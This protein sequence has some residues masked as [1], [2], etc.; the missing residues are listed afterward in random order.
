MASVGRRCRRRRHPLDDDPRHHD[1]F[2]FY[3]GGD[4]FGGKHPPCAG[5]PSFFVIVFIR[6]PTRVPTLVGP[7][8]SPFPAPPPCFCSFCSSSLPAPAATV[9][10]CV[11]L[12]RARRPPAPRGRPVPSFAAV[13][14]TPTPQWAAAVLSTARAQV[15]HPRAAP[16]PPHRGGAPHG[17]VGVCA[18]QGR[19]DGQPLADKQ[20]EGHAPWLCQAVAVQNGCHSP[21]TRHAQHRAVLWVQTGA[22]H[23]LKP[24]CYTWTDNGETPKRHP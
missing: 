2:F 24:P 15:P 8:R 7:C 10:R 3:S 1:S 21:Q 9:L 19:P 12:G 11:R 13:P 22:P 18:R 14:T 16:S 6:I 17:Q 4:A 20:T 23:W 5:A